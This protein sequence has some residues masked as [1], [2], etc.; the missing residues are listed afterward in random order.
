MALAIKLIDYLQEFSFLPQSVVMICPGRQVLSE[1][2]RLSIN[3]NVELL[4]RRFGRRV[5]LGPARR[6]TNRVTSATVATATAATSLLGTR[7]GPLEL[8]RLQIAPLSVQRSPSAQ[9]GFQVVRL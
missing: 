6:V 2:N 9:D 8:V 1:R 4:G 5:G 7:P 3:G